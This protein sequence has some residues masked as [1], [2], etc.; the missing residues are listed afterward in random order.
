MATVI[1]SLEEAH[2]KN[3]I[4]AHMI[5]RRSPLASVNERQWEHTKKEKKVLDGERR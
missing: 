2:R 4:N 1:E 3:E 5:D